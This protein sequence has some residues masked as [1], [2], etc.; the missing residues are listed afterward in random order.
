[1]PRTWVASAT[2]TTLLAIAIAPLVIGAEPAGVIF[3][4]AGP[5]T[6]SIVHVES[7]AGPSP[8]GEPSASPTSSSNGL[9][10]TPSSEPQAV[11]A[12]ARFAIVNGSSA[13]NTV[14]LYL[15]RSSSSASA[16]PIGRPMLV[17]N[18]AQCRAMARA[19]SAIATVRM[20]GGA[21][22]SFVA[23]VD[24]TTAIGTYAGTLIATGVSDGTTDQLAITITMAAAPAPAP[25]FDANRPVL[26]KPL[27][28]PITISAEVFPPI[29]PRPAVQI[30][31]TA[32]SSVTALIAS[33]GE[34]VR[35]TLVNGVLAIP[36]LPG[37]GSYSGALADS[38]GK[39]V[40][41]VLLNVRHSWPV[42]LLVAVLGVVA[43][44][45][46]Q[47]W[48]LRVKPR[49]ELESRLDTI[50]GQ[51]ASDTAAE[52]AWLADANNRWASSRDPLEI[53]RSPDNEGRR[54]GVLGEAVDRAFATFPSLT[55]AAKRDELF[56]PI[57][58]ETKLMVAMVDDAAK[59]RSVGRAAND[60]YWRIADAI[61]LADSSTWWQKT[62]RA[63]RGGP[64]DT[65]SALADRYTLRKDAMDHLATADAYLDQ[66]KQLR[67]NGAREALVKAIETELARMP[68]W[69]DDDWKPVRTAV[70]EALKTVPR[71]V[72]ESF[73]PADVGGGPEP[74]PQAAPVG[75]P[76]VP[77]PG[78]WARFVDSLPAPLRDR[79][80]VGDYAYVA[81][82]LFAA[83]LTGMNTNYLSNA[84]FGSLADYAT[85]F[86]W[87]IAAT[88]VLELAKTVWVSRSAERLAT[89]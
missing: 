33:D 6:L 5:L 50:I 38:E 43:G 45:I 22:C 25:S 87:A 55:D 82:V 11:P 32:A 42:P 30:D 73:R 56:G 27:P 36:D 70:A 63:L 76:P 24:T 72:A 13:R 68:G 9:G 58:S 51:A 29:G 12:E 85:L 34:L 69:D 53:Y 57:G 3:D 4:Q 49:W 15:T 75:Q 54:G 52:R 14:N 1:M 59:A 48:I 46:G 77:P 10:S 17:E 66:I 35:A 78:L 79:L 47:R 41:K 67:K 88:T 28:D 8:S 89:L 19:P 23:S 2:V 18:Q 40:A 7:A 16:P 39:S 80:Q 31:P 83:V 61:A 44:F 64:T 21:A 71:E 74:E 20:E 86:L 26:G 65:P 37:P 60:L 81:F 84:K 62:H